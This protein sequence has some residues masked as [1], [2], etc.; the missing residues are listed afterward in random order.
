VTTA[1]TVTT[2]AALTL[3]EAARRRVLFALSVL[4]VALLALSGWGFSRL[5]AESLTSG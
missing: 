2:I 4:T 1:R 5:A 3:R